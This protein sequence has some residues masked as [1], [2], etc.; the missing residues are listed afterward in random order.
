VLAANGECTECRRIFVFQPDEFA[1][2]A[3]PDIPARRRER[4]HR[5]RIWR[6]RY[7]RIRILG[8][9]WNLAGAARTVTG[10]VKDSGANLLAEADSIQAYVPIEGLDVE[11]S[12][13]ILRTRADPAPLVHMIPE[14]AARQDADTLPMH[15]LATVYVDSL[16]RYLTCPR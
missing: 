4:C 12:A 15:Y 5:Q 11:R 3:R 14:G 13:L 6:A 9:I 2:R 16:P 1:R 10:V 8:K 7:G